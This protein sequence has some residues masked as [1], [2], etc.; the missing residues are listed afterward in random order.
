MMGFLSYVHFSLQPKIESFMSK[1]GPEDTVPDGFS[2]QMK[3]YRVRRK[4]LG[5]SMLMANL[6]AIFRSLTKISIPID[7][8][9]EKA[10]RVF[11][12]ATMLTHFATL[13][14]GLA[15]PTGEIEICNAGHPFP[16]LIKEDGIECIESTGFPLGMFCGGQ[17]STKKD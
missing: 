15:K 17:F 2:V 14:C 16:F 6:H 11:C 10:N 1:I 13:V 9:V 5:A 8:L 4:R 12:E 7:K 3:P